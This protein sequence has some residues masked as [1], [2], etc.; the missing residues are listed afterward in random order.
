[1]INRR[2]F[3]NRLGTGLALALAGY[4]IVFST[5]EAF[6]V[7]NEGTLRVYSFTEGGYVIM[8]KVVKNKDEWKKILTK[9]QYRVLRQQGTERAFTSE[10][11][12]NK[13]KG[14]YRCTGCGLDLFSSEHKFDSRTGWPSFWQPIAPENVGVQEDNSLFTRRTEVHCPRCGG[15]QG[16][17]FNDGPKPTGLRYCINGVA[18][19]FVP[20]KELNTN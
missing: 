19:T 4:P 14:V 17:I 8:D 13:E 1:M 20:E 3:I 5:R 7:N 12:N 11:N 2:N 6:A 10:L 15:H 18:L 16:H 9:E